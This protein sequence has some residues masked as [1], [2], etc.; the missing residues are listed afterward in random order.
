MI[1]RKYAQY[2][3][4]FVPDVGEVVEARRSIMDDR[5]TKAAVTHVQRQRDGRIKLTVVW[6]ED[7]P[8]AQVPIRTG[9]R[10]WVTFV[11]RNIRMLVRQQS[12]TP[13]R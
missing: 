5:F 9:E 3:K 13:L 6:L 4:V 1:I 12:S 11:P 8:G 2:P 10:G 7:D